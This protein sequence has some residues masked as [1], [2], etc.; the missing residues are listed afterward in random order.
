MTAERAVDFVK[1]R[2]VTTETALP[3]VGGQQE[4]TC[5]DQLPHGR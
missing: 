3:R 1:L 4:V 2:F 5:R